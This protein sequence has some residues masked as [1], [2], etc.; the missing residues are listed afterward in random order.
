MAEMR[1]I[2]CPECTRENQPLS[3]V[4]GVEEYRCRA[5]GLVYYGPCGCDTS[6]AVASS[7]AAPAERHELADDWRMSRAALRVENGSHASS[8]TGGC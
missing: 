6:Q 8:R 7:V 4:D 5:C 1:T 3:V 2:D